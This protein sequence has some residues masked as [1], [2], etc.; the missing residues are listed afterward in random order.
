MDRELS[1]A[2][3]PFVVRGARIPERG[4]S[5]REVVEPFDVAEY[6]CSGFVAGAVDLPRL[7][8]ELERGEET[9]HGSVVQVV[10]DRLMLQAMPT[11]AS[12]ARAPRSGIGSLGPND[13]G[14]SSQP[15]PYANG[16]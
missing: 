10:P 9:L 6:V 14:S 3:I 16:K 13:G 2:C 15:T 12:S 1:Y 8:L 4:V 11:S 5:T 7:S